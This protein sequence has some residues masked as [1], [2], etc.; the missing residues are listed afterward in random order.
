M[1]TVWPAFPTHTPLS[2]GTQPLYAPGGNLGPSGGIGGLLMQALIPMLQQQLGGGKFMPAQ[3]MPMQGM[4]DQYK[5]RQYFEQQQQLMQSASKQD[6]KTYENLFLGMASAWGT[7]IGERQRESARQAATDISGW[8]PFLS[9]VA[10]EAF[11]AA[12]GRRGSAVV[13]ATALHRA[14]T[15]VVDPL[16]GRTGTSLTA[17][18]AMTRELFDRLVGPDANLAEMKGIGAGSAGLMYEQ[19]R[20]RG[21]LGGGIGS[22]TKADKGSAI[23]SLDDATLSRIAETHGKSL[24]EVKAVRSAA[25]KNPVDIDKLDQGLAGDM[26]SSFDAQRT[27]KTIKS[28]TGAVAAMREIFGDAGHPDAPMQELFAGLEALTQSGLTTHSAGQLSGMVRKTQALAKG[29]GVSMEGVLGLTAGA[30]N[31]SDQFGLDRGHAV[32]ATQGALAFRTAVG[33]TGMLEQQAYGSLDADKLTMFDQRLRLAAA[34][35]PAVNRMNALLRLDAQ[36]VDIGGAGKAMVQAIREGKTEFAFGGK[37]HSIGMGEDALVGM[38]GND[39]APGVLRD[40]F[41]AKHANQEFGLEARTMDLGRRLQATQDINPQL[42][43]I[44]GDVANRSLVGA[45]ITDPAIRRALGAET[46]AAMQAAL[47]GMDGNLAL[48]PTE[49]LKTMSA[50]AEK[51]IEQTLRDRGI[52]LP[53]EQIKN[54]AAQMASGGLARADTFLSG[55]Q[56]G[57]I[58]LQ[59]YLQVNNPRAI[60]EY[61]KAMKAADAEAAMGEAFAGMGSSGLSQR[62]SDAIQTADAGTKM[63]DIFNQVLGN[64]QIGL[65]EDDPRAA[66]FRR[67][68]NQRGTTEEVH[69]S[70][71]MIT[72]LRQGGAVAQTELDRLEKEGGSDD[73]KAALRAVIQGQGIDNLLKES[74]YD[75]GKAV[76]DEERGSASFLTERMAGS[77]QRIKFSEKETM[78]VTSRNMTEFT[79]LLAIAKRHKDKLG[80]EGKNIT[81]EADAAKL[82][83]AFMLNKSGALKDSLTVREKHDVD[84]LETKLKEDQQSREVTMTGRLEILNL[85]EAMLQGVAL[86]AGIDSAPFAS[87]V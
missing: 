63:S 7:P 42:R 20:Q 76:T 9:Q 13:L 15:N 81:T 82:M 8:A 70:A 44:F 57:G 28:M 25:Q 59:G 87:T 31:L 32:Q 69:K 61:D 49:R 78:K 68:A 50:A 11:D 23:A 85:R 36:G 1:P 58:G 41:Q 30:A 45:G 38:L 5:A 75:P 71:R 3:F 56:Y 74:G 39:I 27:A 22:G 54:L 47:A 62:F 26:L 60:A 6:R 46:G 2:S 10:P 19:L 72:A 65:T 21:I 86:P 83:D 12:H 55:E 79:D 51:K 16:T 77:S 14:G 48:N 64:V 80:F 43:S 73:D 4:A 52:N 53:P 37:Q 35:S 34:A 18:K 66:A 40:A 33:A 84:R 17:E 67:H 29:A 24:D